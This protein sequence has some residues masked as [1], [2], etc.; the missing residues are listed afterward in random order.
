MRR[1]ALAL[2]LVLQVWIGAA[3]AYLLA[4]LG[5]AAARRPA[6]AAPAGEPLRTLVLIPAHDEEQ[7]LPATLHALAAQDFPADRLDIVVLADNCSDAT[8]AVAW[9]AGVTV[10]ERVHDDR[11]KGQVLAWAFARMQR[12][13]PDVEAIAIVDADC[14]PAPNLLREL[15]AALRGGARAAQAIYDVGNPEASPMSGLRWAAFALKHRVRPRGRAALGLSAGLFGTGMAFR[16]E[17]LRAVP[18]QSFSIAEDIEYHLQLAWAG[19]PVAYVD[20][21]SIAS[22]MPTT[23]ATAHGQQLRWESG[24][25]RLA[26]THAASV[27]LAGARRRDANLALAGWELLLPAQTLLGPLTLVCV[28]GSL[29]ARSPRLTRAAAATAAGQLVYVLAGL[30]VAGAPPAVYRALGAAPR[31][32]AA[33]LAIFSRIAR[34]QGTTEWLRTDR[35]PV[36]ETPV[37]VA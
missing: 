34:G 22:N 28:A 16:T 18:W 20:R 37:G 32:V 31:L 3:T 12:E 1:P 15:D 4:L 23:A 30:R 6:S 29:G 24:N 13:R 36:A 7:G 10:W 33:K 8:A 17:L 14:A 27:V 2:L 26:R 35:E 11:G 21:S 25:L 5:L 19:V 9:D